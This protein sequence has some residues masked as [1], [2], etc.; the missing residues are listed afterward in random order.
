M[1]P[2]T[3][4]VLMDG[5]LLGMKQ[6][7]SVEHGAINDIMMV[8]TF[9]FN[10]VCQMIIITAS[11]LINYGRGRSS[12]LPQS[13]RCSSGVNALQD[14]SATELDI[15]KCKTIAGADCKGIP[16]TQLEHNI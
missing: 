15:R 6:M 13:I 3:P 4:C 8:R 5:T 9:L 7:L 14:C 12:I 2:G 1:E 16:A 11:A 10:A